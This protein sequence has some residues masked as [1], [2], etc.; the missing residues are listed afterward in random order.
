[1][2]KAGPHYCHAAF[3]HNSDLFFRYDVRSQHDGQSRLDLITH[4]LIDLQ[5]VA[6]VQVDCAFAFSVFSCSEAVSRPI[7]LMAAL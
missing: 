5:R 2:A 1:M 7:V 6:S 4:H 3:Q